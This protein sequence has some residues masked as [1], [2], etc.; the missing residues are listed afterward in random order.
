M[1]MGIFMLAFATLAGSIGYH[2]GQ[3]T[4]EPVPLASL[5]Q[6]GVDG[7]VQCEVTSPN[8]Q[9]GRGVSFGNHGND[10]LSV[11]LWT[12]G[13]I[14]F[15]PDGP[16]GVLEDGSL[17]MKFPWYRYIE[18]ELIIEGRRLDADAPA[19]RASVSPY[20]GTTGLQVGSLIFPTPGCW[21]VTG[22]VGNENLTFVT[23]VIRIGPGP[24]RG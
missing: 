10:A 19:L 14:I 17:A 7:N 15:A 3:S 6:Q 20:Y 16:G 12:D 5:L 4:V 1:G 23:R 2:L 22:R 11:G 24:V 18:G 13:T 9:V 8:G 21:E